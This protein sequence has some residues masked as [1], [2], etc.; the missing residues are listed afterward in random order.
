MSQKQTGGSGANIYIIPNN[1][2]VTGN[3]CSAC[4]KAQNYDSSVTKCPGGTFYPRYAVYVSNQGT[5]M[6]RYRS[7]DNTSGL[8]DSSTVTSITTNAAL[9]FGANA[10]QQ[11]YYDFKGIFSGENGTGTRYANADGTVTS[12]FETFAAQTQK[13]VPTIYTYHTLKKANCNA[14]Q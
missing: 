7:A 10:T 12:A 1:T 13:T 11:T 14:G 3:T 6:P 4:S 8:Y 9:W 5:L 2:V